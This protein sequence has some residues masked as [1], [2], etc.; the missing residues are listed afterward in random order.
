M[1]IFLGT[2]LIMKDLLVFLYAYYE[3][4]FILAACLMASGGVI[5][6]SK[7]KEKS[8]REKCFNY[9]SILTLDFIA[10]I[11]IKHQFAEKVGKQESYLVAFGVKCMAAI[12]LGILAVKCSDM[13]GKGIKRAAKSCWIEDNKYGIAIFLY[14]LVNMFLQLPESVDEYVSVWYAVDYS[15]G[16]GSRFFIGSILRLFY[17]DYLDEKVVYCVCIVIVLSIIVIAA[18]MLNYIIKTADKSKEGVAFIIIMFLV[19]PFSI[20]GV[21]I[22]LGRLETYGFLLS[23]LSVV[24]FEKMDNIYSKYILITLLS[25]IS[26]AI[27][28][29]NIFMYYPMVMMLFVWEGL[30]AKEN[31][32]I[33]RCL[34]GISVLCTC[35]SFLIFQFC[36][37]IKFDNAEE[38]NAILQQRTNLYIKV[39]ALDLELFQ[40]VS[41]AYELLNKPFLKNLPREKAFLTLLIL[42]PMII[43]FMGLYM[44]CQEYRKEKGKAIF[45]CP[46]IYYILLPLSILPQFVLNIDWGRW[47]L[48]NNIV[49]VFSVLYLTYK[50]DEGMTLAVSKLSEWIRKRKLLSL[51][52][53]L[54]V[55]GLDKAGGMFMGEVEYL[56]EWLIKYGWINFG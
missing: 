32:L 16:F 56:I 42:V 23:L 24:L 9:T 2:V 51:F 27:Y 21:W 5:F 14:L 37:D 46:Y 13:V 47:M 25:C 45:S 36:T 22:V 38:M 4:Y 20:A 54:Y 48:S 35:I 29:G 43:M 15:L 6:F 50:Q 8:I 26:I 44:K 49:I 19:S 28:Q 52:L 11:L 10:A 18:I 3:Y 41:T 55:C 39:K 12:V 30:S 7:K 40:P 34:G 31:V 33:K 1:L 17:R 53:I